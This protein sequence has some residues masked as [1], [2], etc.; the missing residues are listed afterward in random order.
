MR[1]A[2]VFLLVENFQTIKF[3]LYKGFFMENL[4]QIRQILK[5][6]FFKFPEFYNK[7]PVDSQEYRMILLKNTFSYLI[8]SQI[9]LNYFVNDHHFGY[10]AKSLKE[11]LVCT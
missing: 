4:T 2:P 7:F 8:C 9:W 5:N 3:D 10:I 1:F 11:T 6:Y